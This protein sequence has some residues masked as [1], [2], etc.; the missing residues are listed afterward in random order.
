MNNNQSIGNNN[1][2]IINFHINYFNSIYDKNN[3]FNNEENTF[4]ISNYIIIKQ[5]GKGTF[6]QIFLAEGINHKFYA[7]KK[8]IATNL[9]DIKSIEH[10]YKLL[11]D[12]TK[13]NKELNLIQIHGLQTKMLDPTTYII[14]VL[15]D[16]ASDDWE[17][18]ILKKQRISNYYTENELI[19]IIKS[20]ISTFA[21]LQ[22]QNISHRDI[23]PQN[24]LI[25]EDK[26]GGKSYKLADFGEA[27]ELI[28]DDR[29]TDRQTL[30]G[31]E[32]YMSP[33]L[34]KA[35]RSKQIIKYIKHN[36]YKSDL[37]SFGLCCFFAATLTFDSLYD[38]REI[39]SDTKVRK[40]VKEYLG[41]RY[42]SKFIEIIYAMLCLDEDKRKDFI[43]IE[44]D[45]NNL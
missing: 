2:N 35:L 22:R 6:G 34:F 11:F 36:T 41:R 17:K 10:E 20:L 19:K 12:L 45:V 40:I 26:K 37:F 18:E 9:K 43:E 23:K 33:V 29:P 39:D 8:I 4:D 3:F 5:I 14:Y 31:T 24:I 7:L 16:L 13:M 44:K 32:L 27:K 42:S 30:R 25:F 38:I 21:S 28:N 1:N 15:M